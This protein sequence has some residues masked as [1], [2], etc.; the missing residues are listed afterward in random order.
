LAKNRSVSCRRDERRAARNFRTQSG[1]PMRKA[2][3]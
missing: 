3:K 1:F 2:L